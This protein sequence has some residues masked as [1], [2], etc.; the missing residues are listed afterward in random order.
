MRRSMIGFPHFRRVKGCKNVYGVEKLAR[1]R[2]LQ[3]VIVGISHQ[4]NFAQ[5]VLLQSLLTLVEFS[6]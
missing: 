1:L 6:A 5:P 3:L 2:N 4:L